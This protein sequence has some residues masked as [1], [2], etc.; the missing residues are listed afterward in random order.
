MKWKFFSVLR[1]TFLTCVCLAMTFVGTVV[2]ASSDVKNSSTSEPHGV[3]MAAKSSDF[4]HD[5]SGLHPTTGQIHTDSHVNHSGECHSGICCV[6]EYPT[7]VGLAVLAEAFG[8]KNRNM[9]SDIHNS[10]AP[11]TPDRPPQIS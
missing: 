1:M 3:S 5:H 10:Q 8:Q 2:V 6:G 11:L 9:D 4:K 7:H